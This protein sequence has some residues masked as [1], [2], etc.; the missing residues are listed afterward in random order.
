MEILAGTLRTTSVKKN[1]LKIKRIGVAMRW[2]RGGGGG[3]E[4]EIEIEKIHL[5]LRNDGA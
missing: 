2:G 5:A 3:G 1:T 4:R